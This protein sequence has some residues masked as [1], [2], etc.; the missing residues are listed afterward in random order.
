MGTRRRNCP[1]STT[2]ARG[3]LTLDTGLPDAPSG[4]PCARDPPRRCHVSHQR[5][6]QG[7][8]VCHGK[9]AREDLPAPKA[10]WERRCDNI[11]SPNAGLAKLVLVTASYIT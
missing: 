1:V 6:E 11:A 4:K 10:K 8:P 3:A 9:P 5:Y 7:L 2:I